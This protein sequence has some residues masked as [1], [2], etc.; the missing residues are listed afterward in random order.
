MKMMQHYERGTLVTS[1]PFT[2]DAQVQA[3]L[4]KEK[5]IWNEEKKVAEKEWEAKMAAD[6][7]SI[8]KKKK[9]TE[10]ELLEKQTELED[11]KIKF[12]EEMQKRISD[13]EKE[14]ERMEIYQK[15]SSGKVLLN[16]GGTL[17]TTTVTTLTK[18]PDSMFTAM[19]SGRYQIEKDEQQA[20]FID[21]DPTHFRH[22]LNFLRDNCL[23]DNMKAP[24][25][26]SELKAEAKYYQLQTL[27]DALD[28][29]NTE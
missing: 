6:L 1:Q 13:F 4:E 2:V 12:E 10:Q 24:T 11:R 21:R 26:I 3:L 28:N 16:V 29:V 9:Q 25:V 22:I 27:I 18:C 15:Q 17:F 7:E 19:F 23:T 5:E 8:E 14:K 20:I